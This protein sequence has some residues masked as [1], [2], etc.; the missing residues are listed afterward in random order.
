MQ[1][2]RFGEDEAKDL[3][4]RFQNMKQDFQVFLDADDLDLDDSEM[5]G[6]EQK[7]EE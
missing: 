6:E 3:V 4:E 5:V 2:K 1:G 7:A